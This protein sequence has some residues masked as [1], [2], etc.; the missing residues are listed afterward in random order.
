MEFARN[1][2]ASPG[3][4][5]PAGKG[6]GRSFF[7]RDQQM[8]QSLDASHLLDAQRSPRRAIFFDVENGSRAAHVARV[9]E[10]LTVGRM[11]EHRDFFAIGNW[12]IVG[13]ETARLLARH[14]AHLVHSAP[15]HAV[16]DW[17]D[18]R[19]G[20]A[21]GVWLGHARAGDRID[22]VSDDRAFDAVGDVA[23]M[24]GITFTRLSYRRI[25][26]TE[27]SP[28]AARTSSPR[29]RKGRLS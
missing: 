21:A 15:A 14:G 9:V 5:T 26:G 11:D 12:A 29:H 19:I 6:A 13:D 2:P 4:M 23:A 8:S 7:Y 20:V 3:L 22:I 10:H 28:S 25:T 24:L 27:R 1:R 18:L 17:S 16:Q